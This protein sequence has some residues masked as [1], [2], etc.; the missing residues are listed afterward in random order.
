VKGEHSPDR[1]AVRRGHEGGE[2]TLGGR[3]V[4]VERL[5][6]GTAGGEAEV[7]L[8]TFEHFADRDRLEGVVLEWMLSGVSTRKY[9]RCRGAGRRASRA[10]RPVDVEVGGVA[11]I[12]ARHRAARSHQHRWAGCHHRGRQARAGAV[13]RLDRERGGCR[14]AAC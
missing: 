14:R 6:V 2:V 9:R 8:A 12:R 10:G 5:R 7:P 11:Y 4:G 13:G 3:R 1:T